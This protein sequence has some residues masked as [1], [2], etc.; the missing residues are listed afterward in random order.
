MM[1]PYLVHGALV[2]LGLGVLLAAIP[3]WLDF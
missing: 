2:M 1:Y 3:F